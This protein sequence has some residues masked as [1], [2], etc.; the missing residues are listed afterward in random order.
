MKTYFHFASKGVPNKTAHVHNKGGRAIRCL[1]SERG[2]PQ[3]E[4]IKK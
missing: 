1:C 3:A 2:D 4:R